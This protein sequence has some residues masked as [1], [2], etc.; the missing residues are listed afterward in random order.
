MDTNPSSPSDV[1]A[2]L[3]PLV[4]AKHKELKEAGPLL[5]TTRL[6]GKLQGLL[7]V[8][9]AAHP[10]LEKTIRESLSPGN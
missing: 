8:A 10:E 7:A 3:D 4:T 9:I 2:W 1:N 5:A 6:I